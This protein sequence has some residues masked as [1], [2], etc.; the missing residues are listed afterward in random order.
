MILKIDLKKILAYF[1]YFYPVI[2]MVLYMVSD[3]LPRKL[4]LLSIIVLPIVNIRLCNYQKY[5]KRNFLYLV[6]IVCLLTV[7]SEIKYGI[8]YLI[9]VDFYGYIFLLFLLFTYSQ[10]DFLECLDECV[11]EEKKTRKVLIFYF[12]LLMFSVLFFNGLRSDTSW[13]ISLPIL[14]GPYELPHSLAYTLIII[15]CIAS[16][17]FR[18]NQKK[19]YL[20]FMVLSF[21]CMA[22]TG[23]RTGLIALLIIVLSD[24]MSIRE[25]NKKICIFITF[26]LTLIFVALFT[27]ILSNN[28]IVLKTAGAVDNGSITNGRE[29]FASYILDYYLHETTVA[30]KLFGIGIS[31]IRKLMYVRWG[32]E[33]HAHNDFVN[34]LVGYG[35]IG[36]IP[37]VFLLIRMCRKVEK[38]FFPLLILAFLAYGNGLYMYLSFT[39]MIPMLI[40]YFIHVWSKNDIRKKTIKEHF[41]T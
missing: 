6:L 26:V 39:P 30:E 25:R 27:D 2:Y 41:S 35:I 20:V 8:S 24:F 11:L 16:T 29:K 15:Y 23:V 28:P 9:N 34:I 13:G 22:W 19:I 31:G 21:L 7:I 12:G 18:I 14:Y 38:W 4:I 10:S 32:V 40:V 3:A 17:Q 36:I 37:F 1:I 33:I 5:I